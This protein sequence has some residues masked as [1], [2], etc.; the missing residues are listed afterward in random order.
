MGVDVDYKDRQKLSQ[1]KYRRSEKGLK[2]LKEYRESIKAKEKRRKWLLDNR[3]RKNEL[4]YK[5]RLKI[6]YGLSWDKYKSI[7]KKQNNRCAICKISQKNHKRRLNV[8]HCH[9]TKKVRGLLCIK[10]NR[11]IGLFSDSAENL[12]IASWYLRG[13]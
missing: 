4:G 7:L 11:A 8:D 6:E 9:K 12:L 3:D 10:C 5:S 13:I 2:K 1:L